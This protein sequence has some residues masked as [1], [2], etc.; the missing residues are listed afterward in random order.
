MHTKLL[1]ILVL[2]C[3]ISTLLI[4]G[5]EHFSEFLDKNLKQLLECNFTVYYHIRDKTPDPNAFLDFVEDPEQFYWFVK[6]Y[7][8]VPL[9]I[10]NTLK[11]KITYD[12]KV[13]EKRVW[14]QE[15]LNKYI[16][17]D[18]KI[19]MKHV[20]KEQRLYFL[21]L[22]GNIKPVGKY[23]SFPLKEFNGYCILPTI[24]NLNSKGFGKKRNILTFQLNKDEYKIY[25]NSDGSEVTA[26]KNLY[27]KMPDGDRKN[28]I[29][30]ILENNKSHSI[31][32]ICPTYYL[33][34]HYY[35]ECHDTPHILH[36]ID[37]FIRKSCTQQN[38][39]SDQQTRLPLCDHLSFI[40]N[41]LNNDYIQLYEKFLMDENT[42]ITTPKPVWHSPVFIV[43]KP[44]TYISNFDI[45]LNVF[46]ILSEKN[47]IFLSFTNFLPDNPNYIDKKKSL[48]SLSSYAS[49]NYDKLNF[50][51]SIFKRTS[52]AIESVSMEELTTYIKNYDFKKKGKEPNCKHVKKS[53]NINLEVDFVKAAAADKICKTIEQIILQKKHGEYKAR[54]FSQKKKFAFNDVHKGYRVFCILLATKVEG[55]NI[56]RQLLNLENILSLTR[57]TSLYLHKYLGTISSLKRKFMYQHMEILKYARSCESAVV[58]VPAVLYRRSLYVPESFLS[59]YL[60]LSNLVSSNPGSPFFDYAI[61]EFL[62]GYFNKGS[63]KFMSYF[64]S[65][66]SVLYIN[67]YYYEQ[68]FCYDYE[69]FMRLKNKMIHPSLVEQIIQNLKFLLN[70]PKYTPIKK[71]YNQIED[72]TIFDREKEYMLLVLSLFSLSTCEL[73]SSSELVQEKKTVPIL[74]SSELFCNSSFSSAS[75]LVVPIPKLI[76]KL[77]FCFFFFFILSSF[78]LLLLCLFLS[79]FVAGNKT[80]VREVLFSVLCRGSCMRLYMHVCVPKDKFLPLYNLHWTLFENRVNTH[81]I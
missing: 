60:G 4:N 1:V 22:F 37:N 2:I 78:F 13:C 71:L 49:T 31:D 80:G 69:N 53:L 33:H 21:K 14:V 7:L 23:T 56:I 73:C 35:K 36:C 40:L 39:Q 15:F 62:L 6:Y 26:L 45:P 50:I 76:S 43:Y 3:H 48:V 57:Y 61:I 11:K 46:Q 65:I 42:H 68:L 18:V 8:S 77:P 12:L 16:E 51:W 28:I 41:S 81:H 5:R 25:L 38:K 79:C 70:I 30:D 52:K 9:Q 63:G 66:M 19:L 27:F 20:D 44:K 47:E 72:D 24:I 32:F 29:K 55:Y 10:P 67:I 75:L 34:F 58:H 17:P 54:I 74:P 64:I 59:L